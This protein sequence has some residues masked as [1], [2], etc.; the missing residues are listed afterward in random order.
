VDEQPLT[1]QLFHTEAFNNNP[2]LALA[3][4]NSTISDTRVWTIPPNVT[5]SKYL[6]VEV[7]FEPAK[8]P[9]KAKLKCR[10]PKGS[11]CRTPSD[12]GIEYGPKTRLMGD[13]YEDKTYCRI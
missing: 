8:A 3:D 4:S 11:S 2:I 13:W 1:A 5:S 12:E 6:A 9:D 7:H 10:G